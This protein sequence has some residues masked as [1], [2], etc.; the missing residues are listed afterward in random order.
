[1]NGG[2]EGEK[3]MKFFLLFR[4]NEFFIELIVYQ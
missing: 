4:L 3:S 2:I 1:M